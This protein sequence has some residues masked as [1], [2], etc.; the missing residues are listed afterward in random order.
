[1]L[2]GPSGLFYFI[3]VNLVCSLCLF[4]L[5]VSA[6][7]AF[8][9]NKDLLIDYITYSYGKLQICYPWNNPG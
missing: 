4:L 8:W 2:R 7:A 9:H 6:C 5:C 1:M 3:A